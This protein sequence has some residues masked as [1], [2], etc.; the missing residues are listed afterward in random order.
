MNMFLRIKYVVTKLHTE[1][2]KS[3]KNKVIWFIGLLVITGISA[4]FFII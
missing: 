2:I 1:E 4:I 3:N